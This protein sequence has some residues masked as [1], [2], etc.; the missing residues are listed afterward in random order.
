MTC[1]VIECSLCPH[2]LFSQARSHITFT[3]QEEKVHKCHNS[4]AIS[5]QECINDKKKV[6]YTS[7]IP[8]TCIY[9]LHFSLMHSGILRN[10]QISLCDLLCFNICSDTS[11]DQF[12]SG[13]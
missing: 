4:T 12:D 1:K 5:A 6:V 8:P 11:Q 3:P 13:F 9:Y 10:H 2:A 7:Y